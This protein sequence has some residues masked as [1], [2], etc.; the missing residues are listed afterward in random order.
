MQNNPIAAGG[1][2]NVLFAAAEADPFVKVGGLGDVAGSLP[3]AI[4][5]LSNTGELA[6]RV[7]IRLVIPFYPQLKDKTFQLQ[8]VASYNIKSVNGPVRAEVFSTDFTGI[9][10][11]LISGEPIQR[12]AAVYGTDFKSD[13]EKFIFFSL[14]CLALPHA[15]N[16]RVDVLHLN[17]WHTAAA[18][19]LLKYAWTKPSELKHTRTIL[20]IHNL[21]FMGNG[22]E[23]G[24]A[25]YRVRPARN[26][27]LP[28]WGRHLP[29]P[30]GLAAADRIV[31]VS[32]TYAQEIMTPD[33]GCDLQEFLSTRQAQISGILNGIDQ[34]SWNPA[35]DQEIETNFDS[36]NLD[37]KKINKKALL[38]E[39]D[40]KQKTDIPLLILVS[41]MDPQ[42][43]VDIAVE[44]LKLIQVNP[45]QA[46]LLG[47]GD[48]R[49]ESACKDLEDQLPQR[50]RAVMQFDTKLSRRLYAGA[51][52]LMMPSRYEPCGLSQ[53]IAMRYGCIPVANA[54][55][56]LVDTIN[57][58]LDSEN[59]TG[60]LSSEISIESFSQTLLQAIETYHDKKRWQQL[61]RSAITQDF[62][63]DRSAHQY[64]HLYMTLA[65]KNVQ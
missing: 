17:D 40:L 38:K 42:K 58:N 48:H 22:A 2:L 34:Q 30:M 9:T 16:W 49:L 7:D 8:P 6:S 21:P 62:S 60:F 28:K 4:A 36:V 61:V 53:M 20:T 26:R 65:G 3:N 45:W 12:T 56:G 24:L 29:L 39:F 35:T 15:L 64:F 55:G 57:N 50:V 14:A 18:A 5:R 47:T 13:G 1:T 46:I 23:Q 54:T 25:K 19:H 31:A 43:G 37:Q 59:A 11:Y 52:M 41:R 44:A 10:T 32:P 33:Y 51:D 63:W 27:I